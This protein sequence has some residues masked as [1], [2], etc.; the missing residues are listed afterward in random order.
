MSLAVMSLFDLASVSDAFLPILQT[1]ISS[2]LVQ[3]FDCATSTCL[4]SSVPKAKTSKSKK[5]LAAKAVRNS[6]KNHP[7]PGRPLETDELTEH[8]AER[9][10]EH[11]SGPLGEKVQSRGILSSH[12][13]HAEQIKHLK[14]LNSRPA[15]VLNADYQPLAYL[16]LSLWS[17]QE[18]VKGIFSGKV[19][20]VDVYPDVTIRAANFE[21]PLPSVIALNDYVNQGNKRPAFTRRNVFLRDEYKCQYC[22]ERFHTADLSLDHVKPRCMGGQL[23]WENAVT[24]CRKCNGKK[25][26]SPV[27]QLHQLGMRLVKE[28]RCPTNMQLAA[29]AARMVPRRVHP[30]WKPYLGIMVTPSNKQYSSKKGDEQFIDDRYFEEEV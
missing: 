28:P 24:S 21:I 22:N 18:A 16:P 5:K 6:R 25:G 4:F 1:G 9:Y 11:R 13:A 17:W 23:T 8:V 15:L 19:T 29:V 26:S 7:S 30:T 14:E 3:S 27:S 20:V 12:A 2:P 10:N